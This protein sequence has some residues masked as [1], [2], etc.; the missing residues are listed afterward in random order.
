MVSAAS[1]SQENPSGIAVSGSSKGVASA[2]R[3]DD[4]YRLSA[5][6][7]IE[8]ECFGS[9]EPNAAEQDSLFVADAT[10]GIAGQE[11]CRTRRAPPV[12]GRGS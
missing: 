2:C 4:G 10:G 3:H 5:E 12:W 1:H 9:C 7:S 6:E 11:R 8:E